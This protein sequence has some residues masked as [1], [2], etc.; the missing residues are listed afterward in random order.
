MGGTKMTRMKTCAQTPIA[1][2]QAWWHCTPHEFYRANAT[3]VPSKCYTLKELAVCC[4]PFHAHDWGLQCYSL[5]PQQC[6]GAIPNGHRACIPQAVT[7]APDVSP[8][9][10]FEDLIA[11]DEEVEAAAE[12][13]QQL[14]QRREAELRR[15]DNE[16]SDEQLEEFVRKRFENRSYEVCWNLC[17]IAV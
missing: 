9:E 14:Y 11:N 16:M 13:N 8:Q 12:E 1:C 15:R 4:L 7:F 2:L 5:V 17:Q 10:G 3:V 6:T